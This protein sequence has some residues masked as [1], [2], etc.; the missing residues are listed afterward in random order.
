MSDYDFNKIMLLYVLR[1]WHKPVIQIYTANQR[2][3]KKGSENPN[4]CLSP[5]QHIEDHVILTGQTQVCLFDSFSQLD[6]RK[7]EKEPAMEAHRYQCKVPLL[8]RKELYRQLQWHLYKFKPSTRSS[9]YW[10]VWAQC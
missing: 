7:L 10:P 2:S 9:S 3:G 4:R 5:S 8:T 1:L 6:G